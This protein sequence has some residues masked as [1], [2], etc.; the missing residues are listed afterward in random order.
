MRRE[1]LADNHLFDHPDAPNVLSTGAGRH[2]PHGRGVL[3][4]MK[5]QQNTLPCVSNSR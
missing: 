2:W 5:E 1:M 4:D 3:T